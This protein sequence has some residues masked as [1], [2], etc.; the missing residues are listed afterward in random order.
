M[1]RQILPGTDEELTVGPSLA[2]VTQSEIQGY[3]L[4]FSLKCENVSMKRSE[5][6]IYKGVIS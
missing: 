4:L 6:D 3:A 5:T 1:A 2:V